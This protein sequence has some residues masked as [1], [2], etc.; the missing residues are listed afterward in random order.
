MVDKKQWP[1][2]EERAELAAHFTVSVLGH[3]GAV[4]T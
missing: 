4:E 1:T 2:F 3:F